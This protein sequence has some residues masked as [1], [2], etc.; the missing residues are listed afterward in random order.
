MRKEFPIL[1]LNKP[2]CPRAMLLVVPN[3]TVLPAAGGTWVQWYNVT[4]VA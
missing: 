2:V 3:L 4:T 1:L